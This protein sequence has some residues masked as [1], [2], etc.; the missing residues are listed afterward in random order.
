MFDESFS[1]LVE[2]IEPIK[3]MLS[4]GEPVQININD[5]LYIVLAIDEEASEI[6]L[7]PIGF[8]PTYH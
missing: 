1:L 3:E 5:Y 7:E 8:P 4:G 2:D 6:E